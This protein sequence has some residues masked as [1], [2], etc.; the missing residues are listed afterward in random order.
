[1]RHRLL[2]VSA[3]SLL[4]AI[5]LPLRAEAADWIIKNPND[6]QSG[7]VELEPHAN[8]IFWHR[9]YGGG[10]GYKGTGD[11]EFGAGFRATIEIVDP[12]FVPKINDTV[13]ITFGLDVTNCRYCTKDFTLWTPVGLNWS[14]YLTKS[15]S[16]FADGGFVL[17]TDGF[18]H[19]I[20]ADF[21]GMLGGRYHFSDSTA[22]T[23]RIGYP[24]VSVGV[25]FYAG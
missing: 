14:F 22:L 17:R 21:F 1:M 9:N 6:H 3:L 25:S 15:W 24:F 11:L 20:Y 8:F 7:S 13:G 2:L 5:A 12:G 16:V 4:G 23:M 10:R 18:Y 19:D